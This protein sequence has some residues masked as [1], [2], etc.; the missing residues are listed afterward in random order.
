MMSL[1]LCRSTA[2]FASLYF[3]ASLD[4]LA[5]AEFPHLTCL[6]DG[7]GCRGN[8]TLRPKPNPLPSF[9][10]PYVASISVTLPLA[11]LAGSFGHDQPIKTIW[12]LRPK[13]RNLA[14]TT[15]KSIP[16][17]STMPCGF[18]IPAAAAKDAGLEAWPRSTYQGGRGRNGHKGT[19][20]NFH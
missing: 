7:S 3:L 14:P 15:H 10:P 11:Y 20:K 6:S 16:F 5:V 13:S 4:L 1:C 2:V 9:L 17:S 12:S 18:S 8:S 19:M